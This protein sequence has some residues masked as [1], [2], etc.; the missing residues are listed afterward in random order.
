[1]ISTAS[2]EKPEIGEPIK[3]NK[4][5]GTRVVF[6]GRFRNEPA[7]VKVYSDPVKKWLHWFLCH[8]H[9][10]AVRRRGI[11]APHILYS[12]YSASLKSYVIVYEDLEDASDFY[13]MRNEPDKERRLEGF[14][15]LVSLF[16]LMHAKGIVQKDTTPGNFLESD[17][18]VH[19]IDEDR[20]D[21]RPWPLGKR[22]SLDNL[23]S[24]FTQFAPETPADT[25]RLFTEYMKTRGWHAGSSQRRYLERRIRR[26]RAWRSDKKGYSR[27]GKLLVA[28]LAVLAAATIAHLFV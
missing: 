4:A 7:I 13:W 25:D 5:R 11:P 1:M 27:R 26:F 10:R 2:D 15:K 18:I 9:G 3:S 20:M 21:I 16:A 8:L 23:A 28:A 19:A 17:G 14:M 12:G 22:A 24:L 6:K